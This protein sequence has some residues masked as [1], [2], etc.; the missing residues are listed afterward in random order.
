MRL[1]PLLLISF[2][3]KVSQMG[4]MRCYCQSEF[5]IFDIRNAVILA[6]F[7]ND[8]AYSRVMYMRYFWKQVMLNLEIQSANPP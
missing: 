4:D 1:F 6:G 2:S 7:S 5:W 3:S 8:L